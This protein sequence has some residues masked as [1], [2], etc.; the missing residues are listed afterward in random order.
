MDGEVRLAVKSHPPT[1]DP[2]LLCGPQAGQPDLGT[3]CL[4]PVTSPN[5]RDAAD[6]RK[7]GDLCELKGQPLLPLETGGSEANER[8]KRRP[9]SHRNVAVCRGSG[10]GWMVL[11]NAFPSLKHLPKMQRCFSENN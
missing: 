6:V 7:Q 5:Q 4:P 2:S 3:C 11:M 1:R 8:V 10:M 9:D